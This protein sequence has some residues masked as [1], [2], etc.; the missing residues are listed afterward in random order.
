MAKAS[1]GPS[2]RSSSG[3]AVITVD[4]A[5]VVCEKADA[6]PEISERH[7]PYEPHGAAE[8][9]LYSREP[10]ILL[11]GPAGTGKT[12]AVLEK[13]FLCAQRYGGMRALLARKTRASLSQSVLVTLEDKVLWE[14]HPVLT[15]VSR[16]NRQSY[17]FNNRSELVT[18]SLDKPDRI[19]STEFD[20]I[21]AFEATELTLED[22]QKLLSRLRNARMPF[23]QAI[24]DCNPSYPGHWLNRRAAEGAMQ[25][26]ES[27]HQDNPSLWDRHRGVW[28]AGGEKYLATLGRLS[29]VTRRRLLDGLWAAAEGLVYP[30][31][32][33]QILPDSHQKP[34]LR[35]VRVYAGVDWGFHEPTAIVVGALCADECL[36]VVEEYYQSGRVP[37][38]L[39]RWIRALVGRWN[40]DVLFCDRSRPEMMEQLRRWDICAR[41]APIKSVDLGISKVLDRMRNGQLKI[42]DCCS[43]LLKEAAEYHY[44]PGPDGRPARLPVQIN[45]HA[46]DA[47]RYL[48]G[49]VDIGREL[50]DG[51]GVPMGPM[52]EVGADGGEAGTGAGSSGPP[53]GSKSDTVSAGLAVG[54][55]AAE[56]SA[57]KPGSDLAELMWGE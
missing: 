38:E 20:L 44:E 8:A 5:G 16:R 42:Y 30:I 9:L 46:L 37:T 55:A 25:R 33:E 12:R 24:A 35:P 14:R 41:P 18:G 34:P 56:S 11:V 36:Y 15:G 29:G 32:P 57:K 52:A 21:A 31:V 3:A 51:G 17:Q 48:V 22:W 39:G 6:G 43:N 4:A 49:G 50:V 53:D 27:R 1:G 47:L 45:D 2:P 54:P 13:V 23:Q 7:R 40:I 10:E 28:T 26:L 19:M